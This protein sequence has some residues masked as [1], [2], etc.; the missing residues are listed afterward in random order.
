M[1]LPIV[2]TRVP[3]CVDAVVD[4]AT[5]LLVPA[6]DTAGVPPGIPVVRDDFSGVVGLLTIR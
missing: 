5:G 4:G 3:G 1:P 6:R 2:A